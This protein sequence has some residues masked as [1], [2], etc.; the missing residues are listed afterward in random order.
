[1]EAGRVVHDAREAA[2]RAAALTAA[3]HAAELAVSFKDPIEIPND[4]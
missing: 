2:A 3:T 1:M 4:F